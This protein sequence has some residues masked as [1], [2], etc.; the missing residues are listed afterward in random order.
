MS[1][2][3]ELGLM[4]SMA[5]G[6]AKRSHTGDGPGISHANRH[7]GQSLQHVG[8]FAE[9]STH[10]EDCCGSITAAPGGMHLYPAATLL[11]T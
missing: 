7:F 4:S 3:W 5:V 9:A 1:G 2:C 10:G 11:L 6:S 8:T